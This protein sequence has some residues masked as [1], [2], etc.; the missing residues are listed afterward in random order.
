MLS[1][2]FKLD[3]KIRYL[4][5]GGFNFCVSYLIYVLLCQIAGNSFYQYSLA[6]S[7]ALSSVISFTT[8]KYLVFKGGNNWLSEYL[9]CCSTWAVSYIINAIL[10]EVLVKYC[11]LNVYL[12]Q[13]I[14]TST[15]AVITYILFKKFAFKK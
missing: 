2:W 12:S 4:I 15:V 11:G 5:V 13:F 9:K 8:Q 6:L 1:F 3:D 10:L 14:A 7:W